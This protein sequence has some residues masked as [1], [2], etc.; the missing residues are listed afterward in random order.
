MTAHV[1]YAIWDGENP[2]TT[3]AKVIAEIIRTRIGFDGLL[4][5]DDLAMEALSGSPGERAGAA[6]AAGCDL[7]LHCSGRLED[8]ERVAKGAGEM[9]EA[10]RARLDR[11]LARM[12]KRSATDYAT[13][14]AKRDALLAYAEPF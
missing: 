5:S 4:L 11:A 8:G 7:A 3:S 12:G 6:L 13:L 14:A 2:A 10:A 9:R 1:L